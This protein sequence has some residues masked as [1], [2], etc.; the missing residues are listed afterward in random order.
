[1]GDETLQENLLLHLD[2]ELAGDQKQH[3]ESLLLKDDK[4]QEEWALLKRTKLDAAE[5]LAFPDKTILYRHESGRLV[6]GRFAR[7]AVAAALIG[8]G[9]FVGMNLVNED[10]GTAPGIAKKT[11]LPNGAGIQSSTGATDIETGIA[12]VKEEEK[13]EVIVPATRAGDHPKAEVKQ[14]GKNKSD[15]YTR[16]K[17]D[18]N[19]AATSRQNPRVEKPVVSNERERMIPKSS[20]GNQELARIDQP[21]NNEGRN[22][23]AIASVKNKPAVL[24]DTNIQPVENLFARNASFENDENSDDHIFMMDEDKVSRTKAAGFLKKIKRT[25]ERTTKI[26]PGNSLRIAGFEFAVK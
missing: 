15:Y 19:I 16:V 1:M 24:T 21:E 14:A 8:A 5:L 22:G 6:I 13:Q 4:L 17:Q 7:W 9:I 10:K 3:L 23:L 12:S 25:V 18:E 26:K 20:S 2:N 11:V